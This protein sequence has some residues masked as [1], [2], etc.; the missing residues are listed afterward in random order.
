MGYITTNYSA[1]D[2]ADAARY[3]L[4]RIEGEWDGQSQRVLAYAT[5]RDVIGCGYTFV[6][7]A[8]VET[9]T[10]AGRE[11]ACVTVLQ[12]RTATQIGWKFV[13]ERMGPNNTRCPL[14]ILDLLTPTENHH[15]TH[16]R[17]MSRLF[18]EGLPQ[19][20]TV[21]HVRRIAA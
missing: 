11:V 19:Q 21:H 16:F 12:H 20:T 5:D 9:V 17:Q 2:D 15:A 13:D 8:A 6:T 4:S 7:Y 14:P 10:P 3:A 18:T 1:K